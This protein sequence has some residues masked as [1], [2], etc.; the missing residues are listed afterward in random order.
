MNLQQTPIKSTWRDPIGPVLTD[1]RILNRQKQGW[2]GEHAKQ[3]ALAC[4]K[5]LMPHGVIVRCSCGENRGIKH[6]TFKYLEKPGF[7]CPACLEQQRLTQPKRLSKE[8]K[9]NALIKD[10]LA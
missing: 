2:Y 4:S 5:T 3:Q 6:Y 10:Y 1:R 9:F 7:Y 8:E